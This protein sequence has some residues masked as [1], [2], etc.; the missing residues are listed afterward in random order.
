[1]VKYMVKYLLSGDWCIRVW[2]QLKA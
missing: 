1:M 2:G